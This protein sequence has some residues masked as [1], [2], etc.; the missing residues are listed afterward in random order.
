MQQISWK[1]YWA[2]KE[3]GLH[4]SQDEEFLNKEAQEKLFHL[5]GGSSLLDFG[6]GSADLLV[7]YANEHCKCVG[8]DISKSM[9]G[10]ARERIDVFGKR[11]LVDLIEA[12][13]QNLWEKCSGRFDRIT[14]AGVVQFMT[15]DQ[16]KN[17]V[18]QAKNHLQSRGRICLFDAIDPRLYPLFEA[19]LF[20]DRKKIVYWAALLRNSI[21]GLID[22]KILNKV[23][24]HM[25]YAHHPNVFVKI[26]AECGMELEIVRSMYYEYRYHAIFY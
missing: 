19:G 14:S 11:D 1:E 13:H 10:K 2:N 26:A 5:G 15:A 22:Y 12:D 20:Y 17:F 8:V 23:N 4:R 24:P 18:C 21:R 25:G 9:L 3:N 6:C 16:L 7:Y